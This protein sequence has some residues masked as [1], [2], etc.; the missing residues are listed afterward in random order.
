MESSEIEPVVPRRLSRGPATSAQAD[1][2]LTIGSQR[3]AAVLTKQWD[4]GLYVLIQG[5]PL[6]WVEDTG[7][8]QTPAVEI[9]VRVCNIVRIETD[10]DELAPSM[11][12]FRIGLA[13][14][15]GQ[16][17][18]LRPQTASDRV[19][20]I[21]GNLF[22][23][24]PRGGIRISAGGMIAFSLIATP[25]ILV[26]M[27]WRHHAHQ[28]APVVLRNPV[29]L[30]KPVVATAGA[31]PPG[32]ANVVQPA[33]LV[34]PEPTP[35]TLGLPG[36]EPFLKPEVAKKLELTPSQIDALGR[37]N[38]TTQQALQDLKKYW[39]IA[40]QGEL[41]RRRD[42]LLGVAREEALELLTDRQ[43]RQWEA[44]PR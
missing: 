44:M 13:R 21:G 7:V 1:C 26:A 16:A 24:L 31:Q 43:R 9:A 30:Q 40:D 33:A 6:F 36:I 27:A 8:L 11:P 20:D 39:E 41:A 37:L 35:E 12:A 15:G 10:E 28:A 18:K 22:S 14:V 23:L 38:K 32:P 25:L 29:D 3:F 17:A 34:E 19:R 5:S 4:T 42:V 2:L